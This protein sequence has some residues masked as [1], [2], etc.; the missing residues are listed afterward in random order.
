MSQLS[1]MKVGVGSVLTADRWNALVE[2]IELLMEGPAVVA[3][4]MFQDGALAIGQD[5]QIWNAIT[6]GTISARVGFQWGSGGASFVTVDSGGL[7]SPMGGYPDFT[8]WNY[9][10]AAIGPF[11]RVQVCWTYEKWVILGGDCSGVP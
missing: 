3:P 11:L 5:Y 8:A 2:K 4:L 1:D 6:T 10:G 9:F 7:E